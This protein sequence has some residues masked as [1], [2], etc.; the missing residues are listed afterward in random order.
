MIHMSREE[1]PL[2]HKVPSKYLVMLLIQYTLCHL[3]HKKNKIIRGN[4]FYSQR[5]TNIAQF[6]KNNYKLNV[7]DLYYLRE[8]FK[9]V[10]LSILFFF[11]QFFK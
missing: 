11:C 2:A 8:L 5:Y 10:L 1:K 7:I 3:E 9:K 6:V 4:I